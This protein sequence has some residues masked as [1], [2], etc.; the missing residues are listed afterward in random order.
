MNLLKKPE[1][2][3]A[4]SSKFWDDE[5]ISKG[6]LEAHLNPSLEAASRKHDFIDCSVNWIHAIAPP[7]IYKNLLDLGCGPGM[8]CQRLSQYAYNITGVDI[9]RRSLAYAVQIATDNNLNIDYVYKNYMEL[10]Y[11]EEFN[12]VLFIYC[13]FAALTALQ[14][15]ILLPKIYNSMKKGGKLILDVFTPKQYEE[16]LE[17]NTWSLNE[18][19]GFWKP[20]T[21][22]VLE[23][24]FNYENNIR[25]N[26][27][28]VID[29]TEKVDVYRIW[30]H[31][32]TRETL[33]S[34][35]AAA[36]FTKAE[37]FSDVSGTPYQKDSK[38][39]CIVAEK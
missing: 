37:I 18:G 5:H 20:A 10:D 23:S 16:K 6:M 32:Y 17:N 34:E 22:L 8:Y 27:Y 25:L 11:Q 35:F 21:H 7:E 29:E 33:L 19:G 4:S 28:V 13:D 14:R 2:Y 15:E 26:Q 24:H 1:L 31:Y 3:A 36:G 39:I 12:L 9:S 38:T 30:D